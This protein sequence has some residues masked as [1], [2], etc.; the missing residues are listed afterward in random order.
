MGQTSTENC[1]DYLPSSS[2]PGSGAMATN[3]ELLSLPI[4]HGINYSHDFFD[5][6]MEKIVDYLGTP[7]KS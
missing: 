5:A 7:E 3:Q 1:Q 2:I 6:M 4:H